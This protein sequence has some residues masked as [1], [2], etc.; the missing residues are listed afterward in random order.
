[1]S[2]VTVDSVAEGKKRADRKRERGKGETRERERARRAVS[3]AALAPVLA[4]P[5]SAS[6]THSG[7][8]CALPQTAAREGMKE[9]KEAELKLASGLA[10]ALSL[11]PTTYPLSLSLSLPQRI[12]AASSSDRQSRHGAAAAQSGRQRGAE[13]REEGRCGCRRAQGQRG[14]C[15]PRPGPGRRRAACGRRRYGRRGDRRT[16]AGGNTARLARRARARVRVLRHRTKRPVGAALSASPALWGRMAVGRARLLRWAGIG[17]WKRVDALHG[18][19][20]NRERL[21]D[22]SLDPLSLGLCPSF[23]LSL[24]VCLGVSAALSPAR[25][26][27]SRHHPPERSSALAAHCFPLT[28]LASPPCGIGPPAVALQRYGHTVTMFTSHHEPGQKTGGSLRAHAAVH[29]AV[30]RSPPVPLPLECRSRCATSP[31]RPPIADRCFKE[32]CDGT[33]DVR[34]YGD[35]CERHA[36]LTCPS[37]PCV[38]NSRYPTAHSPQ[39]TPSP[40]TDGALPSPSQQA[41]AACPRARTRAICLPADDLHSAGGRPDVQRR[42]RF[43]RSGAAISRLPPADAGCAPP[44]ASSLTRGLSSSQVSACIPVFRW[45]SRMRVLFY[46][47]FPDMVSGPRLRPACLQGAPQGTWERQT[48]D[49][50]LAFDQ[51]RNGVA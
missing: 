35:W 25:S 14:L 6:S 9:K 2:S 41:A 30:A 16:C 43:L 17:A 31:S 8:V 4:A 27:S 51:K 7:R 21:S 33:L 38:S 49:V 18:G 15:P 39:P 11:S 10:L 28:L 1:M 13:A 36:V 23:F 19:E 40:L 34:V 20:A 22:N 5:Y 42:R 3:S 48:R 45:L 37:C 32:T 47:H 50:W 26:A 12:K 29:R 24:S 46:C 44:R